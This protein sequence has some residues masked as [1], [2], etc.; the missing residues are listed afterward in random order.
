MNIIFAY[1]SK[2]ARKILGKVLNNSGLKSILL[3]FCLGENHVRARSK[4]L[5]MWFSS[6]SFLNFETI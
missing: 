1:N 2:C 6:N 3:Y 5:R 4:K